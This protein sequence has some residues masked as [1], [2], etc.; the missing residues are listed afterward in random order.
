MNLKGSM[1][2]LWHC[3]NWC[4]KQNN[5]YNT[6]KWWIELLHTLDETADPNPSSD[7]GLDMCAKCVDLLL[8]NRLIQ[9]NIDS[10]HLEPKQPKLLWD[11]GIKRISELYT[12]LSHISKIP[13]LLC[14]SHHLSKWMINYI[15]TIPEFEMCVKNWFICVPFW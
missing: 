12:S 15:F 10:E 5:I 14:L 7:I 9:H 8:P 11:N 1:C 13:I 6:K 3:Y 4:P 2:R